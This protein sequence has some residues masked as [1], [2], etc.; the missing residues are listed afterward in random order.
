MRK[1]IQHTLA[2][3]Q[4]SDRLPVGFLVQKETCFLPVFEVDQIT[5][6]VF[7]NFCLRALRSGQILQRKEPLILLHPFSFTNGDVVAFID[8]ANYLS[9]LAQDT[10]KHG[11]Q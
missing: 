10:G 11:K 9:I 5:N 6:P 4:S 7:N 3:A 8:A 1:A 2:A